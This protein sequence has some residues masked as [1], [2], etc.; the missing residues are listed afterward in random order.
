MIDLKLSRGSKRFF[1]EI[2]PIDSFK[3]VAIETYYSEKEGKD[4]ER[5]E[6]IGEYSDI[7]MFLE[8]T[9]YRI[10]EVEGVESLNELLLLFTEVQSE[11]Q[12]KLVDVVTDD[13]ELRKRIL[14]KIL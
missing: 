6:T 8:R 7:F 2:T 12:S 5:K 1:L 9:A 11:I 10:A 3:L 13:S 14:K 4:L